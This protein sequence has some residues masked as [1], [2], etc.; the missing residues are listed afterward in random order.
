MTEEEVFGLAES[1]AMNGCT[2]IHIVGGLHPQKDYAW[3]RKIVQTVRAADPDLHIKAFTAVEIVRFTEM[4]GKPID[5]ILTD[6]K[7]AGLGSLP[8][9]GAEIFAPEV[10]KQICP[11]KPDAE[12]WFNV[13]QAAHRLGLRSNA[14][15]L[16]GHLETKADR[17]DHLL[18]LRSFQDQTG[19]FQA[20]VPLSFHPEST[21]FS[22]LEKTTCL[23]DLRTLAISRLMLDNFD[24]I[25]AYWVSL[26]VAV[27]QIALSYG[28]DDL[29][30]TVSQELIHHEAGAS[31]PVSLGVEEII[32][33]IEETGHRA[34]ERDSLYRG[35][36]R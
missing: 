14:T 32:R 9:G 19:G 22:H 35:V 13:H 21:R 4:I 34:V 16:Y 30:G 23:D 15:M 31:S 8:G 36:S 2:E 12:A 17:L 5:Y 24:H 26:G 27:A 6:L 18:R 10:R 11:Q 20:F 7:E 3:Y 25:K 33:L 29:D 1:A 28:A